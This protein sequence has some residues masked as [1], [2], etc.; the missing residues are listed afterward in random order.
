[1]N[2]RTIIYIQEKLIEILI[3]YV[4]NKDVLARIKAFEKKLEELKDEK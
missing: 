2:L 1:M 3:P 4:A